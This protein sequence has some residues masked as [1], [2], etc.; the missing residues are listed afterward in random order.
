LAAEKGETRAKFYLGLMLAG[1]IGVPKDVK[2]GV[3]YV[4]AAANEGWAP[5]QYTL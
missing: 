3:E 4:S 5:A 1:G 2:D